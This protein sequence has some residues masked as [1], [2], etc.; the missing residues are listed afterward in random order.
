MRFGGM[1]ALNGVSAELR[2]ARY[3]GLIGPNGAG[4]TTLFNIISGGLKPTAGKVELG[5][6]TI[7]GLE[8]HRICHAGIGRTFQIV[9]P[10]PR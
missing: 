8:P 9:R 1:V 10:L 2:Q 6:R 5:G 7:S 3:S 4:K